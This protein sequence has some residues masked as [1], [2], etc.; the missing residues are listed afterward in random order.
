MTKV[1]SMISLINQ[2][3]AWKVIA[4]NPFKQ[5]QKYQ[6]C[7]AESSAEQAVVF[8]F[9]HLQKTVSPEQGEQ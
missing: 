3:V 9:G 1:T 7:Y 2:S 4:C 6:F 8:S 5:D